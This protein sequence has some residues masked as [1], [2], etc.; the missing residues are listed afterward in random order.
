MTDPVNIT[1]VSGATT[2]TFGP[3]LEWVNR[4]K[5]NVV[6]QNREI[7]ANGAQIIEEFQQ[8]GGYP[9]TLT[10]MADTWVEQS[11]VVAL[12]ALADSPMT[13]PM[14]L[15]YNDGTEVSVRFL[16][17][18]ATPAVEAD[19]IWDAIPRDANFPHTLTI[20]LVQASA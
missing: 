4:F 18:G 3:E 11:I 17:D 1:L 16:Y 15:T 12:Q 14:T 10:T 8:I 19:P 6:A 9:I 2:I 20:R 5:R 7:A 13:S